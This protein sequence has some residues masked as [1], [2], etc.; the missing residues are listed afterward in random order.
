MSTTPVNPFP[1]PPEAEVP[2]PQR[3]DVFPKTAADCL[4]PLA[5]ILSKECRELI[6]AYIDALVEQR[7]IEARIEEIEATAE[8]HLKLMTNIF[9]PPDREEV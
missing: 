8:R 6:I 4:S 9:S 2:S 5:G 7:C 1:P 3:S